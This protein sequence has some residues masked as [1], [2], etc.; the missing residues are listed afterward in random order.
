MKNQITAFEKNIYFCWIV[1]GKSFWDIKTLFCWN[2]HNYILHKVCLL[3]ERK[4]SRVK[5]I[6]RK[7][8]HCSSDTWSIAK[9]WVDNRETSDQTDATMNDHAET[10]KE[11]CSKSVPI[12]TYSV[13]TMY[14]YFLSVIWNLITSDPEGSSMSWY[15]REKHKVIQVI[16]WIFQ[17]SLVQY[18]SIF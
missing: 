6:C 7:E 15:F 5:N 2:F 4:N 17:Y 14:F 8:H 11:H 10:A 16:I 3:T 12:A 1:S 13:E 9:V 18:N